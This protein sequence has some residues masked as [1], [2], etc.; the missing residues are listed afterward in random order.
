MYVFE[1]LCA[2]AAGG[3]TFKIMKLG[4]KVE[5]LKFF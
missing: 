1:V 3:A 5:R 2:P 4:R